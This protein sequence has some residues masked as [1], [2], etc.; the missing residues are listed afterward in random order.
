[1]TS[2]TMLEPTGTK[3]VNTTLNFYLDPSK[4]GHTSYHIGVADYYR[5]KFDPHPVRIQDI[6]G[7]E[8][9]FDLETHG[10]QH[11]KH[12]SAEKDF[13]DDERVRRVVYPE[14][15]ELIKNITGATKVHVFS[16][17]TRKDSRENAE[18]A[19]NQDPSL[20]DGNAPYQKI[21]PARFIHIDF[22]NDGAVEILKDNFDAELGEKLAK[23]RWSVRRSSN[24][25]PCET[26]AV[27]PLVL[28]II[29]VWRPIKPISKDPLGLCDARTA[30]DGDLMPVVSDLMPVVSTLPPKGTG[31]YAS[32]SGGDRFELYYKRYH[33]DE[34]RY[35]ADKMQ[36]HEIILIKCFDSLKDGRATR[37]PHSAFT[38]PDTE[39]DNTRESIEV[40]SLVF[41]EDQPA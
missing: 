17:I 37:C 13:D 34:K 14:T 16:H 10:L 4:G 27:S 3:T 33:P 9:E 24:T 29:N 20:Q 19:I 40:R 15:A 25:V 39:G 36:P 6:R 31:Q 2:T 35:Y 26:Y 12:I 41:F 22:S 7:R 5:R 28:K 21:V 1:M 38:N 18:A 11:H 32:V 30:R 8:H 23:T